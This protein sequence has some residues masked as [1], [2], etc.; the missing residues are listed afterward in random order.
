M[1]AYVLPRTW[2]LS[3]S[4]LYK[5]IKLWN[6]GIASIFFF[7]K[8]TGF[9]HCQKSLKVKRNGKN[10]VQMNVICIANLST[11]LKHSNQFITVTEEKNQKKLQNR[12]FGMKKDD[13]LIVHASEPIFCNPKP[14]LDLSL[15]KFLVQLN[16]MMHPSPLPY[17]RDRNRL[18]ILSCILSACR[19]LISKKGNL[20]FRT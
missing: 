13:R 14:C 20:I 10:H 17:Y 1:Q 12:V 15:R 2:T 11:S 18:Y 9:Q 8:E 16:I 4:N 7:T 3:S 6:F 5:L 19:D